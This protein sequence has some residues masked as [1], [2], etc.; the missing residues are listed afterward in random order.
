MCM[1]NSSQTNSFEMKH[2]ELDTLNSAVFEGEKTDPLSI[3]GI[4][5]GARD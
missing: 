2:L 5:F 4:D 3:S 1:K